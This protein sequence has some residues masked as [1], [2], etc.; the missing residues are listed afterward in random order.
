M[1]AIVV[2]V[3]ANLVGWVEVT[4]P[5]KPVTLS[6]IINQLKKITQTKKMVSPPLTLEQ[7][8]K[9][10]QRL[11]P[12]ERALIAQ[13]LIQSEL[14]DDLKNLLDELYA[15]HPVNKITDDDIMAEVKAVRQQHR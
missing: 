13:T 7:I 1:I 4:K 2:S 11:Q 14:H 15:Q 3:I 12:N 10:V 9:A 8:I 6:V 5:N